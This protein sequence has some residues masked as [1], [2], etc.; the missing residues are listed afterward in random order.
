MK[1]KIKVKVESLVILQDKE[2][3]EYIT[4]KIEKEEKEN[5]QPKL[6]KLI[7]EHGLAFLASGT[8]IKGMNY[9]VC[10]DRLIIDDNEII[11]FFTIK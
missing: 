9:Y 7:S 4:N 5:L 10:L 2:T 1:T 3:K 11:I 6:E 8:L